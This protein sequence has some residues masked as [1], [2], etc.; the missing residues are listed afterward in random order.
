MSESSRLIFGRVSI[1]NLV[2]AQ[3][4]L[5]HYIESYEKID[6]VEF[7]KKY[8]KATLGLLNERDHII[9]VMIRLNKLSEHR[10]F[11]MRILPVIFKQV[12]RKALRY[13]GEVTRYR[14]IPVEEVEE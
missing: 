7:A 14:E 13:H 12:L 2:R 8:N 1:T 6:P 5:L 3:E 9:D 10:V 4:E 11:L